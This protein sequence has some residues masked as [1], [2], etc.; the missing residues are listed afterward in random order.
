MNELQKTYML[1]KAAYDSAF[2]HEDWELVDKL[3]DPMLDA[4]FALVDWVCEE[5][6][7]TGQ[8]S[9]EDIDLVYRNSTLEQWR[10]LVDMGTR[11]AV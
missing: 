10:K 11:L 2:K 9:K 8:M 7:K 4:E 3:E 1:A 5:V 6:E